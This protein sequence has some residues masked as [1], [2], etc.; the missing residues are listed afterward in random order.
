MAAIH[1]LV[2]FLSFT[3][4]SIVVKCEHDQDNSYAQEILSSAQNEKDWLVSVR[5]KIHQYPEL[6]FQEHNTSALIRNELDKL[7]IPY[8][9][10]VAKTGIVAQIGSGSPPIIAI[11]ADIDALPLQV[12]PLYLF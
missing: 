9:Y 3:F 7:G 8:T 5:R 6:A 4:L 1:V 12:T 2:V 10:P 11:R